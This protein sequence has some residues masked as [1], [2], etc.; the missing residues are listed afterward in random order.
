MEDFQFD[1]Q[2]VEA[3]QLKTGDCILYENWTIRVLENKI[4][5]T[6]KHGHM[7]CTI[8]GRSLR[9]NRKVLIMLAG[10]M[11]VRRT[12]VI[13]K[14]YNIMFTRLEE[15]PNNDGSTDVHFDAFDEN[16]DEPL[17]FTLELDANE[18]SVINKIRH[19]N[20]EYE[21]HIM[22]FPTIEYEDI[23]TYIKFTKVI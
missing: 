20:D 2:N 3:A 9:S 16:F 23:N 8:E 6:G 15:K 11:M 22:A 5:K 21:L 18:L 17:T 14:S 1:I 10:H 12:N 19:Q 7:K 4:S 13:N